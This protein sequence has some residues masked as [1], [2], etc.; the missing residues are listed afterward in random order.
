MAFSQPTQ[1]APCGF[2]VKLDSA[3]RSECIHVSM[4]VSVGTNQRIKVKTILLVF[5]F[6]EA[7]V[8]I[9]NLHLKLGYSKGQSYEGIVG[10]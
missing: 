2:Y 6:S 7:A 3:I 9:L 4:C 10:V 5:T 8:L 1:A